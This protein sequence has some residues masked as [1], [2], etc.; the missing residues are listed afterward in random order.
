VLAGLKE[1]LLAPDMVAEALAALEAEAAAARRDARAAVAGKR[2]EL[3]DIERKLAGIV[4][5]IEDGAWSDVLKARLAELEARR[6]QLQADLAEAER[7]E[8][9]ELRIHPGLVERYRDQVARLEDALVDEAIRGEAEAALRALVERVV[10]RPDDTTSDGLSAELHSDLAV[11][12]RLGEAALVVGR[13]H[14]KTP[15]TAVPG[16]LLSVDAGTRNRRSHYIT[17]P[18]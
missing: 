18:V 13:R 4:R 14:E 1:R 10:L 8:G 12:L 15:G 3:D 16:G 9:P 7:A 2:R 11:I 17:I 5:V 6:G